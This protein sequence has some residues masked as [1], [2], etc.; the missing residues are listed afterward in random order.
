MITYRNIL[1][2]SPDVRGLVRLWRNSPRV[3]LRMLNQEVI[4]EEQH[5]R[6]LGS[7]AD[8]GSLA[9]G[10]SEVRV[11]FSD[12]TPF[13]VISLKDV[14][15]NS[16]VCDWG[17][18][19]GEEAFLRRGLGRRLLYDLHE[20]GFAERGMRKMY[21]AVLSDN[22]GALLVELEAGNK[23]EGLLRD[24]VRTPS[25]ALVDVYLIA[26]FSAEWTARREA[27]STWARI[28]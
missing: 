6:W 19:V 4:S 27:L 11:A 22:H 26:Q 15:S 23:I 5:A 10:R 20:W 24:H 25:G 18:Y 1:D 8:G 21:T 12:G 9:G 3:R 2:V 7:L 14:D 16:M 17:F 28:E 13:G